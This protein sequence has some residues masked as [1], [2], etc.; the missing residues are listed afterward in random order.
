MFELQADLYFLRPLEAQ[1]THQP[2]I[3]AV[4]GC[5]AYGRSRS[6]LPSQ[7]STKECTLCKWKSTQSP[8]Y[9]KKLGKNHGFWKPDWN[10]DY[11]K[12]GFWK[13]LLSFFLVIKLLREIDLVSSIYPASSNVCKMIAL[14]E[15]I[16]G[17]T[18]FCF[19]VFFVFCCFF[20]FLLVTVVSGGIFF[21][22]SDLHEIVQRRSGSRI[23]C[24]RRSFYP[25]RVVELM[26]LL[27]III[28]K[29]KSSLSFHQPNV[30]STL[31]IVLKRIFPDV[32][33]NNILLIYQ[34]TYIT[35]CFKH[36]FFF[37][38]QFF[39]YFHSK[40]FNHSSTYS[41]T[42][43]ICGSFPSNGVHLWHPSGTRPPLADGPKW[44]P[45]LGP[46]W[47]QRPG[48]RR[49]GAA[50]FKQNKPEKKGK[51]TGKCSTI[52]CWS[53]FLHVFL[54]VNFCKWG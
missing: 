49:N 42:Y 24:N 12:L 43:N 40:K 9:V 6:K 51:K 30:V 27:Y 13:R 32:N 23:L 18:F 17:G 29:S 21:R 34:T 28:A 33:N 16:A 50:C 36:K 4:T 38:K 44:P 26:S 35:R 37:P 22:R 8:R 45:G 25:K 20:S 1:G 53:F 7:G 39:T 3:S 5:A 15:I 52:S 19:R 11:Q 54:F 47:P 2:S 14:S 48:K 10:P 41:S 46:R 31:S